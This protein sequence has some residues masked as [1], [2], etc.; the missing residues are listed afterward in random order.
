MAAKF[1]PKAK[2]K[3]QKIV[4][5]VLGVLLLGVLAYEVPSVL[6]MMN[7]K[8]ATSSTTAAPPAPVPGA[9]AAPGTPV[10]APAPSGTLVD[11]DPLPQAAG[12]QLVSFDRFAS[13]DPFDQQLDKPPALPAPS[14]K[15][16]KP[17]A[18]Q[19]P[20]PP[21]AAKPAAPTSAKIS[22]NG[23]AEQVGVGG[24]FPQ[25][26]PLFV[27]VSLTATKAKIGI[28]GGSLDTGSSTVTLVKGKKMTL[29]NTVDGARYELVLISTR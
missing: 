28:S 3:R 15:D 5:A 16:S 6:K 9:P 26:D 1:D 29:Q 27:L 2:A 7:K 24:S 17:A 20:P 12:G 18:P 19:P 23:V 11:S 25:E 22:V 13:K 8:P 4:A 10:A 14:P 21:P